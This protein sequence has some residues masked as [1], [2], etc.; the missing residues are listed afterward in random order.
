MRPWRTFG[1][2]GIAL[3]FTSQLT[4]G[5]GRDFNQ[6][7]NS[8]FN[9]CDLGPADQAWGCR[10]SCGGKCEKQF[11]NLPTPYGAI[12]FSARGAEGISWNKGN[13]AAAGQSA[14]ASCGRYGSNCK[15]VY[16]FQDTCAALAVAKGAQ[17]FES[18]TGNTRKQAEANATAVCQ[19]HWGTC[20]SDLSAC[21]FLNG[22]Q[23][24]RTNPPPQPHAVSWGAIAYSAPDMQAGYASGKDDRSLAGKD[25]MD[26]CSQ[27]GR[28]CVLRA[29][30][31]KQCG[32]LA[33][34][35]S[36]VGWATS[37]Q[38]R[39]AQQEAVAQ[40]TQNGGQ[41]CMLHVLFCSY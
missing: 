17:H 9:T 4:F 14:I 26:A 29:V 8:C 41:N 35:R 2:F 16:Q 1:L 36:F 3:V 23:V 31:N 18:A 19:Q 6:C 25:A 30:F 39:D 12:A 38:P 15:V 24:T 40:C 11:P 7:L 22:T 37:A 21:S 34:D 5:Q 20:L 10:E 27:R 32:A 13:W 28:A 33:A